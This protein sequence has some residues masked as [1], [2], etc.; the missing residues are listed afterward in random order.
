MDIRR[1]GE[2]R[3]G[4][5]EGPYWDAAE[6]VLYFV[7]IRGSA[8]WRYD[9][10]T[11]GFTSWPTPV[12]PCA[13]SRTTD[14]RHVAVLADGFYEF[15]PRGGTFDAIVRVD[16][17]G[18]EVA[19]NDAK[20][21]RQGRFVAGAKDKQHHRPIAGLY[22]FDGR[23]V[24][25]LDTGYTISNGPCWSPDGA[26]FY[27]ADT[28]SYSIY[29]Y[30]YAVATGVVSNKR[31]F[32]DSAHAGWRPDG[33]TVDADG[34]MWSAMIGS[35][36]IVCFNADGSVEREI[37]TGVRRVTSVQFGGERLDQLYVTSS[38]LEVNGVVPDEGSGYLYAIE[39][40]GVTGVEEPL[41][42]A[43]G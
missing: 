15:D 2:V 26:T 39:D 27:V 14:G 33:A 18:Q 38:N 29:A 20:V 3:V 31:L 36:Q 30:D 43:F 4:L 34:R 41:A 19:L 1:L 28:L 6:Q 25:V 37:A 16:F 10:G 22:S 8:L 21:D 42:C 24:S 5:G 17:E 13:L 32:A 12:E 23:D 35:G 9:P 7:D 11:E 40:L